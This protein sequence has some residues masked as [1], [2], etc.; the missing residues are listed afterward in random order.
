MTTANHSLFFY[1][2]NSLIAVK[3][4]SDHRAVFRSS[5][6]PLAEQRSGPLETSLLAVEGKGTVM[7]AVCAG[8][9]EPHTYSAYG[10]NP[11]L[12]SP[13]T[14][15]GFNGEALVALHADYA[16]GQGHRSFSPARMRFN[17]PDSLS[18]FGAGGL[19]A[20]CYCAGDP[21][22]Y[23]DPTGK[24]PGRM[25]A[26]GKT[27]LRR[28]DRP[29]L[30]RTQSL[31][32]D[33]FP[34]ATAS[35]KLYGQVSASSE[36]VSAS[37]DNLAQP[38]PTSQKSLLGNAAKQQQPY[39]VSTSSLSIASADSSTTG[40]LLDLATQG[41]KLPAYVQGQVELLKSGKVTGFYY[42]PVHDLRNG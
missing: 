35:R 4:G 32:N 16:L 25:L 41:P 42:D 40:S 38:T 21:V 11:G 20:Y 15:L 6:V 12:P 39:P 30:T 13:M 37:A 28:T 7:Q 27:V 14:L 23:L 10:H 2:A 34:G 26:N 9:S 19:N 29:G 36:R 17:A 31:P 5:G 22:N 18:P 1:Q 33:A 3:Q 8:L 24:I